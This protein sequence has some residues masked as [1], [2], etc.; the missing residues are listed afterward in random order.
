[1]RRAALLLL[2]AFALA[3]CGGHEA[4]ATEAA[5]LVPADALAYVAVAPNELAAAERALPA[6]GAAGAAI[7]YL[8][9]GETARLRDGVVGFARPADEKAFVA[10]LAARGE[11]HAKVRGWIVYARTKAPLDDVRHAKTVLADTQRF[12]KAI[13]TLPDDAAVRAYRP[14]R[15]GW[16]AAALSLDGRAAKL[17]VHVPRAQPKSAPRSLADEIPAGAVAAISSSG[18]AA[19]PGTAAVTRALSRLLET[20]VAA[21]L[22]AAGGPWILYAVPG[23]PVPDVTFAD[24]GRSPALGRALRRLAASLAGAPVPMP[25]ATIDLGPVSLRYGETAGQLVFSDAGDPAAELHAGPRLSDAATFRAAAE[26][27]GLP[28]TNGGFL[29]VDARRALAAARSLASLAGRPV[30]AALSRTLEPLR[31]YLLWQ[32]TAGG[33]HTTVYLRMS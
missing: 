26:R 24:A 14:A 7:P 33:V 2:A 27:A 3:G 16:T 29:Y 1:M 11:L 15:H 31:A 12:R 30:P 5:E 6:F 18:A 22:T 9:S 4:P 8:S 32:A 19:P 17:E 25:P 13:A 20:D 21:P 23:A 28:A 10:T